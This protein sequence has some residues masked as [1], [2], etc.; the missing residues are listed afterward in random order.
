MSDETRLAEIEARHR[1]IPIALIVTTT[2]KDA[3]QRVYSLGEEWMAQ[4]CADVE[5]LLAR[6][7]ALE[8]QAERDG[9][10]GLYDLIATVDGANLIAGGEDGGVYDAIALALYADGKY[11][12]TL[13]VPLD[14]EASDYG[15]ILDFWKRLWHKRVRV[16]VQVLEAA[17]AACDARGEGEE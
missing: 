9:P 3:N 12:L 13:R 6:V 14:T 8:A 16:T 7:R 10:T 5:W 1:A 4:H 11:V 15:Y 2:T 17:L